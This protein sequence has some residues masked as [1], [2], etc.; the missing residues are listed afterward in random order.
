[1]KTELFEY[2]D[3]MHHILL[4]L[5]MLCEE[6]Y[7]HWVKRTKAYINSNALLSVRSVAQGNTRHTHRPCPSI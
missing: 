7:S 5:R 1:M 6:S 2:D 3:V 4:E